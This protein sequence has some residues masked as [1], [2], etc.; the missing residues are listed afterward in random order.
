MEPV[1]KQ[2]EPQIGKD[3]IEAAKASNKQS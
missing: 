3:L 1:Y 2:F